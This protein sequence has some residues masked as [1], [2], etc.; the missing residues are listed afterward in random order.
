[1]SGSQQTFTLEEVEKLIWEV[2]V[3]VSS[4]LRGYSLSK[5][6]D[7]LLQPVEIQDSVRELA[8]KIK[9]RK[10]GANGSFSCREVYR[11]GWSALESPES[12]KL[13]VDALEDA[14]WIRPQPGE[15]GPSGGRPSEI[16]EVN[17]EVVNTEDLPLRTEDPWL[18]DVSRWL[19]SF[20]ANEV[21]IEKILDACI[22][23]PPD[24]RNQ[25]DRNRIGACL[26]T[27]GWKRGT[28]ADEKDE[29]GK[30]T[31]SSV[32]KRP[33]SCLRRIG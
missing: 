7:R 20:G 22:K 10:L 30:R 5:H 26:R 27:L 18:S 32:Y 29:S 17:R 12:V 8:K 6:F 19:D 21:T 28:G 23:K 1:M 33:D 2:A 31:R 11:K 16:Y 4:R 9:Q 15:S 24:Q 13:A 25:L 3:E 14:G